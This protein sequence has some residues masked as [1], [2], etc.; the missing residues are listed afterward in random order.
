MSLVL[1]YVNCSLE[2]VSMASKSRMQLNHE[3]AFDGCKLRCCCFQAWAGCGFDSSPAVS[4][5]F[6][7]IVS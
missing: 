6:F 2:M 3:S 5:F 4:T 7:E 1:S